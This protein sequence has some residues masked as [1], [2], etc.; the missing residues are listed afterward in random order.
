[1]GS[2]LPLSD[3]HAQLDA[4]EQALRNQDFPLASSLQT[5][6]DADVRRLCAQPL[7]AADR[8]PLQDLLLR[9]Q[10]LNALMCRQ[11]DDVAMLMGSTRQS[12]HA[13]ISY[14]QAQ[15]LA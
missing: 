2:Q 9:H 8:A 3:L 10:R 7:T 6:H 4:M 14:L 11:R 5:D 13:S 1:M 12:Q 15:A